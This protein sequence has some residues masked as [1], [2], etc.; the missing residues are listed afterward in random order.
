MAHMAHMEPVLRIKG[1]DRAMLL[2][3]VYICVT[4]WVQN[5]PC[6]PCGANKKLRHGTGLSVC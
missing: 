3:D 5:V 1:L 6:V 4:L 2:P